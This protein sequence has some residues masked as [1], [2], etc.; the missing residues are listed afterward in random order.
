MSLLTA[1]QNVCGELGLASPTTVIGNTDPQITQLLAL[2]NREGAEFAAIGGRWSGWPELNKTYTFNLVPVGPYTGQTT[3]NSN[4]ITGLSSTAGIQVGYGVAGPGIYQSATITAVPPT[5]AAGTVQMSAAASSTN[6]AGSSFNF[7]QISYALPSDIQMFVA[8]TFWDGNFRWPMLGPISPQERA[9]ILFGISPVGPRIRFWIVDGLMTIQ[10]LPGTGQT[11]QIAYQYIS[12]AFCNT[13]AGVPR[14][15][16]NGVCQWGADTDV[17]VWPENTLTL[18]IKWRFLRAKG[19]DYSEEY[20]TYQ[21]AV[22]RQIARS[23]ANRSLPLNATARGV[24]LLGYS[25]I[26]D[27]GYGQITN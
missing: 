9:T 11:D 5:T 21:N 1:I 26:P 12:N 24:H 3:I 25:N 17:Y 23:G 15:A 13:A 19:L 2:A 22:N 16:V 14:T 6:P 7:G 10:P 8:A 27:S 18:G 20:D 4:L